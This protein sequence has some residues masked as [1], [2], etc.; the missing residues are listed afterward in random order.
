MNNTYV[1]TPKISIGITA[2]NEES[3]IK[4][5]LISLLHQEQIGFK[6]H[7]IIL[8]SDGS[9]DKTIPEAKAI[10]DNRIIFMMYKS[11]MGKTER[12][13]QIMQQFCGDILILVDADI[14]IKNTLLLSQLITKMKNTKHELVGI[15]CQPL[16]AKSFFEHCI[17]FSIQVQQYIRNR[18]NN[19]QNYL[20]FKGCF[21]VMSQR[22]AKSI[23]LPA[24]AVNNDAYFY[25]LGIENDVKPAYFSD[26]HVYYQ[27][28]KTFQDHLTQ[29]SRFQMSK[30]ELE[31]IMN[32]SLTR[33][34][35]IPLI[36]FVRASIFYFFKNPFYFLGYLLIYMR[37]KVLR[38]TKTVLWDQAV[39]TKR[40]VYE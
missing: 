1:A 36:L 23:Q 12:L 4:S 20:S 33:E 22:F 19:G 25:F 15:N 29:S 9:N 26:L 34:Y 8:I 21:L 31:H 14:L 16:P 11:R 13:N 37:T 5:L 3:N 24:T 38:Q 40:I 17:N 27:S 30:R 18:W 35:H 10:H 7:E 6:L 2:Y 39:S 32:K 28:P